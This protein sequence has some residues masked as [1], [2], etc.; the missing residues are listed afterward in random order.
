M[1]R[2]LIA[3]GPGLVIAILLAGQLAGCSSLARLSSP[4]PSPT[5]AG[6]PGI[7]RVLGPQGIAID[8]IVS[9]DAG[10]ADQG[11]ARTAI[12]FRASGLDQAT[13]LAL[14]L[15]RFADDEALRRRLGDLSTCAT[16]YV[17]DPERFVQIVV[18]PYVVQGEGPLA[19]EFE[20]VLTEGLR[21][22]AAD[23]G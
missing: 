11:L 23:G 17:T 21:T 8:T 12:S 9:G 15:Y 19:P 22:A 3:P 16:A 4:E 13:P 2:A 14:R 5:P 18:T 10:C 6:F 1:R 20:R 7:T